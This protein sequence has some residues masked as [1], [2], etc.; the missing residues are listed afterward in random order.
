VKGRTH[1]EDVVTTPF[2]PEAE[3]DF[4]EANIQLEFPVHEELVEGTTYLV[5]WDGKEYECVA[6]AIGFFAPTIGN[7]AI[8]GGPD[9]GN[10]EPFFFGFSMSLGSAI[11]V[12]EAG[13]HVFSITA[14][15]KT[16]KPLDAKFLPDGIEYAEKETYSSV[17]GGAN[18]IVAN[19]GWIDMGDAPY[20]DLL[21]GHS[22]CIVD[23]VSSGSIV[24]SDGTEYFGAGK[25]TVEASC[26]TVTNPSGVYIK[27]N[28][29][30]FPILLGADGSVLN[31][32][33]EV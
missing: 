19:R 7:S 31:N 16:L 20:S 18:E 12:T 2:L 33:Y 9:S 26:R 11:G 13:T 30:F 25:H 23:M 32:I 14:V 15:Q 3:I 21:A 10:G 17:S 28:P 8:I 27:I 22:T 24:A 29:A 4:P 5:N 6:V 1:Y